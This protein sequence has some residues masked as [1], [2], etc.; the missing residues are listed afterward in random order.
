MARARF[1]PLFL[2]IFSTAMDLF[3]ISTRFLSFFHIGS[4]SESRIPRAFALCR[5][6]QGFLPMMASLSLP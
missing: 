2:S 5:M 1:S 6:R 3:R 4:S